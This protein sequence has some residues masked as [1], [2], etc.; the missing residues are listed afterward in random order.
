MQLR[1][2]QTEQPAP[3]RGQLAVDLDRVDPGG[4]EVV[5]VGAG[6]GAGGVAEDRDPAAARPRGELSGRVSRSSQ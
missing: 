4:G 2:A 5:A 6:D 1:A 3:D